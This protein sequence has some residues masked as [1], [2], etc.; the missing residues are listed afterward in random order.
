VNQLR[1]AMTSEDLEHIRR[2]SEALQ[3]ALSQTQPV[4]QSGSP[5]GPSHGEGEVV[6]GEFHPA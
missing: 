2:L 4:P 6:E 3:Q 1:Q 5:S